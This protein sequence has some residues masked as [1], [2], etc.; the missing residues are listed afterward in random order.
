MSLKVGH[1]SPEWKLVR[2]N[3]KSHLNMATIWWGT[4]SPLHFFTSGG[5]TM[6]C[7]PLFNLNLIFLSLHAAW[8]GRHH[9][10]KAST[11][12]VSPG[13]KFTIYIGVL[14]DLQIGY[15]KKQVTFLDGLCDIPWFVSNFHTNLYR[16][17]K[18]KN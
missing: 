4:T 9:S 16:W 3:N 10:K 1:A 18:I 13:F 5:K 14:W 11:V 17:Y 8:L 12:F 7:P 2:C 6:F 15:C